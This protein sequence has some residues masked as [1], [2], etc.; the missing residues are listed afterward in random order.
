[1]EN[2]PIVLLVQKINLHYAKEIAAFWKVSSKKRSSKFYQLISSAKNN[3][4]LQ[5]E[6]LFKKL[7]AKP[8]TEKNDYLWRNEVRLL[9]EELEKFLVQKEHEHHA[10]NNE[11]Y[12][13]W[14]LVQAYKKL[15]YYEGIDE[16]TELLLKQKDSFASY[17]YVLDASLIQ[18]YSLRYKIIDVEKR[19]KS[20]PEYI[21]KCNMLLD[22][23]VA[24]YSAQINFHKSYYNW[25]S[26]N[27]EAEERETLTLDTYEC[28]L[29]KNPI[30]NFFNCL[31]EALTDTDNKNID[32][33]IANIDAALENIEPIYKNN[34]LMQEFRVFALMGK[35]RELSANGNFEEADIVLK[36]IKNDIDNL[37]LHHRTIFY[38]NYITNLV[39]CK[40]YNEVIHILDHEFSTDN[41]LYKNMLLHNR[42]VCYMYLRDTKN[43]AN[44]ITYDL[45]AAPFP[46]NYVLKTIKSIYFYLIQDFDTALSI[47]SNVIQSVAS[48]KMSH[49]KT[50]SLLYKKLYTAKQKHVLQK[51]LSK[52][53]VKILQD[54]I[55]EFEEK[56]PTE[57]KLVSVYLWL[58]QEIKQNLV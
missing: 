10:K 16:K 27:H 14:H 44:Y 42:L 11:A 53:D 52:K 55:I 35:G 19:R 3:E 13:D 46:Q 49:H 36:E 22:D 20:Y 6:L 45:D 34:K 23:L 8:Y 18:L 12:N 56:T 38:V 9:K 41:L 50:I 31:G 21:Q 48:D 57:F 5:K 37:Y 7:F 17:Q 29:P 28:L 47:I 15:E 4:Q 51:K 54:S 26:Y 40:Q 39:K 2:H 58:K 33:L 32:H 24:S 30:S 43:L 25:L 1:M